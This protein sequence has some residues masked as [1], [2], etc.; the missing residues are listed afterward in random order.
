MVKIRTRFVLLGL[1]CALSLSTARPAVSASPT[2]PAPAAAAAPSEG[3]KV[4]DLFLKNAFKEGPSLSA[5]FR[6]VGRL[7]NQAFSRTGHVDLRDPG[8]VSIRFSNPPTARITLLREEGSGWFAAGGEQGVNLT[9]ADPKKGKRTPLPAA[10]LPGLIRALAAPYK[11]AAAQEKGAPS[12][13]FHDETGKRT[14]A[15]LFAPGYAF[16]VRFVKYDLEG[17]GVSF[18]IRFQSFTSGKVDDTP[19]KAPDPKRSAPLP[20]DITNPF[21]YYPF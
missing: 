6:M 4:L 7:G 1:A 12:L 13:A 11:L 18:F 19:F 5:D 20:D 3:A 2:P 10:D 17:G 16:P 8:A 21:E 15:L 14:A 9:F